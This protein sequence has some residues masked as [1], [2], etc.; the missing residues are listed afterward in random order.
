MTFVS[1]AN[2]PTKLSFT[3]TAGFPELLLINE[4]QKLVNFVKNTHG[5]SKTTKNHPIYK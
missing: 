3:P 2:S 1:S 5:T 4:I